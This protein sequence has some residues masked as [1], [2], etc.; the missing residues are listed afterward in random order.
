MSYFCGI[1]PGKTG[2]WA[3]VNEEGSYVDAG[4]GECFKCLPRDYTPTLTVLELVHSHPKQGVVSVFK[5]GSNFGGWKAALEILEYPYQLIPPQKWQKAILGSFPV[6][7]SKIRAL[8]FAQKRWPTL[9]L[10]R[11]DHGLVDALCIALYARSL[12]L[13]G[14]VNAVN[15]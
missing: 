3:V 1:D 14:G 13:N 6:G 10:I 7:E 8:E 2:A 12:H 15:A 11:K 9:K 5:F 4:N